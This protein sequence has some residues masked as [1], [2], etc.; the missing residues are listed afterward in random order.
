MNFLPWYSNIFWWWGYT[1][2]SSKSPFPNICCVEKNNA[3]W[4]QGCLWLLC[5]K[6]MAR[7]SAEALLFSWVSFYY[8]FIYYRL[9][10]RNYQEGHCCL[11]LVMKTKLNLESWC[12]LPTQWKI[13]VNIVS[14]KNN[15]ILLWSQN[16]KF[17][18][19]YVII[20]YYCLCLQLCTLQRRS[21]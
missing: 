1:C 7:V 11:F 18:Y 9:T 15:Y 19:M 14:D 2:T 12:T 6:M 10:R 17:K 21:W 13:Q 8:Y 16:K 5:F 20:N 3:E 4:N